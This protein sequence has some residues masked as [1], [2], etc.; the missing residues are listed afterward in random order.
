MTKCKLEYIW[1]DGYQPTQSLRSKTK[2]VT[3]ISAKI[4]ELHQDESLRN[5]CIEKGKKSLA[6][7][8]LLQD[9]HK[10]LT[11]AEA[12]KAVVELRRI[13]QEQFKAKL[14]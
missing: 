2:V 8:V 4:E 5:S 6:F 14:R 13:L 10:T 9:T 12:E 1:L 7:S 3:D 11:D